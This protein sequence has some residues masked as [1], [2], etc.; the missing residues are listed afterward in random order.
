HPVKFFEKG[1]RPLEIVTSRQWYLRNGGR[2]LRLRAEL[3]PLGKEP[4][5]APPTMRV[6]YDTWLEGLN[7]DWLVSRQRYFGVPFPVWYRVEADGNS[8]YDD[9]LLP[10]GATLSV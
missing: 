10:R 5:C 9:P 7:A 1:E 4:P 8:G 6:R 3:P 2:A